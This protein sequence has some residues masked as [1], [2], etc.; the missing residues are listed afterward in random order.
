[1]STKAEAYRVV[2]ADLL[3]LCDP[4]AA[5]GVGDTV[6]LKSGGPIM[7]IRAMDGDYASCDWFEGSTP[8]TRKFHKSQLVPVEVS[9]G[10]TDDT[11]G[12]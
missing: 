9:D 11:G 8:H 3:R 12:K 4:Q 6:R 2:F 5:M 7:T 10:M 1:M